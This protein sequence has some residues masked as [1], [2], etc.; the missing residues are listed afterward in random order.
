MRMSDALTRR[1]FLGLAGA[2]GVAALTGCGSDGQAA[3]Q[4]KQ[5]GRLRAVYAGGGAK[6]V[7]DPHVQSLFVDLARHKAMYEKLVELGPDLKPVPRLAS[8]WDHD[9]QAT[10][11]RFTLRDATF[12]DGAK[13]GT[14]DVLYSLARIADPAVPDRVAQS[15]LATLD[16]RRCK[17]VDAQTVE[18]VPRCSSGRSTYSCRCRRCW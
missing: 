12:H 16:L 3:A 14:E 4:P 17:A 7:L 10:T 13:L 6:E 8:T 11:W 18:L 1:G 2:L 15:S 9:A 5:G